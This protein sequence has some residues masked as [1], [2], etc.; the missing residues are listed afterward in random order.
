M[1][2]ISE[3]IAV[4]KSEMSNINNKLNDIRSYGKDITDLQ[5]AQSRTDQK[6]N[7]FNAGQTLL[8]GIAAAIILWWE[9]LRRI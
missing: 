4:I 1:S 5:I 9:N 2:K 8:T 3:D 7:L 6:L